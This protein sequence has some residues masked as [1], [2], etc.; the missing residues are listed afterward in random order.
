MGVLGS[1]GPDLGVGTGAKTTRDVL[2]NVNLDVRVRYRE[3]LGVGIDGNE[4]DTANALLDHAV[5]SVRATAAY[6]HDL[7]YGHVVARDV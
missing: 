1:L 2:A 4:L 5:D 3:R 7:D 6:A